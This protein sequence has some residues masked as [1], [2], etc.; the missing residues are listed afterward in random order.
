ML[1]TTTVLSNVDYEVLGLVMGNK[2]RAVHMGRDIMAFLKN[3][4]GGEV[5]EYADLMQRVRQAA[6]EE[7]EAEAIKLGANGIMGIQFSSTQVASGM[8]EIIVYGTAIKI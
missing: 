3:L 1:L 2:V 4:T 8:A 6:M 5:K 7:M